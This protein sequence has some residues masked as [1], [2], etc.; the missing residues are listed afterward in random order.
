MFGPE[1]GN[2]GLLSVQRAWCVLAPCRWH[3]QALAVLASLPRVPSLLLHKCDTLTRPSGSPP[4]GPEGRGPQ[5]LLWSP[6][7]PARD[8]GAGLALVG[9]PCGERVHGAMRSPC[10]V[11]AGGI[12][13][14][15]WKHLC[16]VFHWTCSLSAFRCQLKGHHLF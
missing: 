5:C 1:K 9:L 6:M 10:T 11:T 13:P 12:C 7:P 4:K 2:C 8:S 3:T 14:H 16:L 15:P